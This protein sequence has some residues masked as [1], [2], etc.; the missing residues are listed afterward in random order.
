MLV[1]NRSLGFGL[2]P[3]HPGKIPFNH[4]IFED[5]VFTFAADYML[6]V[7]A[8]VYPHIKMA[9]NWLTMRSSTE[10]WAWSLAEWELGSSQTK[11]KKQEVKKT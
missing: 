4:V 7:Y 5:K 3:N 2:V 6:D 8:Y 9:C 11:L 1:L 10:A